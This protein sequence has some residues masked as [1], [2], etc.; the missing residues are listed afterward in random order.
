MD[1]APLVLEQEMNSSCDL[2]MS[3]MNTYE[4]RWSLKTHGMSIS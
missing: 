2:E 3:M 4:M 1:A